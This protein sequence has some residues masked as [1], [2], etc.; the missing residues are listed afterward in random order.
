MPD[1]VAVIG[2]GNETLSAWMNPRLTTVNYR[3]KDMVTAALDL[4]TELI[5]RPDEQRE[6]TIQ[7]KPELVLRDSA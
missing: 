2:W 4:L 7:I 6:R 3:M 5:E 1:D